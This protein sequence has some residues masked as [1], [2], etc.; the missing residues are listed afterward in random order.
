MK[1]AEY[2]RAPLCYDTCFLTT[3]AMLSAWVVKSSEWVA[4]SSGWGAKSLTIAENCLSR[5]VMNLVDE[6]WTG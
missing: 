6:C 5:G 3:D 4:K 1:T 2:C